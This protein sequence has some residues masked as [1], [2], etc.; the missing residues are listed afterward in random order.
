[1]KYKEETKCYTVHWKQAEQKAGGT[2]MVCA[3]GNEKGEIL[4]RVSIPTATPQ[5]TLPILEAYFKEKGISALGIGCF[6]PI[7]LKKESPTYGHIL[8]TPK[9]PWRNVDICGYFGERLGV[10]IGFDTD[11]NGSLLGEV[12]WGCARGLDTAIHWRRCYGGGASPPRNAPSR[13]RTYINDTT[14][15]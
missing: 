3:L 9:L 4:E 10:P 6:G 7:D 12:T 5:E 13:G 14:G 8:T 11:V 1:M 15:G 2:K